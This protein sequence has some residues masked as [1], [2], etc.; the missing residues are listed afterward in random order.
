[1]AGPGNN[2][3]DN[4]KEQLM[5][6][7]IVKLEEV[8]V[9]T[10]EEGEDVLLDLK[11]EFYRF[12]KEG[13]QWKERGV[14]TVKLL[15]AQRKWKNSSFLPMTSVQEHAGN[16]KSCVWHATDFSK[17]GLFCIQFISIENCKVFKESG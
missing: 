11:A 6:I 3:E 7:P 14:G 10:G 4:K 8:A 13:N 16:E 17:G 15:K 5:K 1:M 12:Y 9:T 2:P